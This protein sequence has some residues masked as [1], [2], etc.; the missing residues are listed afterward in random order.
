MSTGLSEVEKHTVSLSEKAQKT[1]TG[2]REKEKIRAST[3]Q[4]LKATRI[5]AASIESRVQELSEATDASE[6]AKQGFWEEFE[7]SACCPLP[8]FRLP[9]S[10]L[11]QGPAEGCGS[12]RVWRVLRALGQ[13]YFYHLN[14]FLKNEYANIK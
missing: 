8:P 3:C 7:V 14:V 9:S 10:G 12:G 6:K 4:P 2:E 11:W 5:S 1:D 13:S